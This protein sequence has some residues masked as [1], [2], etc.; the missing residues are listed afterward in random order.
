MEVPRKISSATDIET[1]FRI[2]VSGSLACLIGKTAS[3]APSGDKVKSRAFDVF[4]RCSESACGYKE[5][6]ET[7]CAYLE[8]CVA[9]SV[10]GEDG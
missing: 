2:E 1:D 10:V 3:K 4:G 8:E 6:L 7:L 9:S 5:G